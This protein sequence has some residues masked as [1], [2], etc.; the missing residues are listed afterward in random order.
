MVDSRCTNST[1]T[2]KGVGRGATSTGHKLRHK[3]E[4]SKQRHKQEYKLY[5]L[6]DRHKQEHRRT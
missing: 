6:T 2:N 1:S 5:N 3:Q 4:H